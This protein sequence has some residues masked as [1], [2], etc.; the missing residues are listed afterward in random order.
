LNFACELRALP[1]HDK[2]VD[3]TKWLQIRRLQNGQLKSP[4]LKIAVVE[5]G[6]FVINWEPNRSSDSEIT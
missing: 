5:K 1:Q 4:A 2:I 6:S 3:M